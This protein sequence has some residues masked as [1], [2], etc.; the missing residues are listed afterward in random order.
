MKQKATA[1]MHDGTRI[2]GWLTTEHAASSY[3]QPVFVDDNGN[4]YNWLGIASVS[5]APSMGHKGGSSTSEAK[6]QSSREN[7]KRGGRPKKQA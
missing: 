5:A 2:R 7:G 4:A 6:R 3:G 1:T